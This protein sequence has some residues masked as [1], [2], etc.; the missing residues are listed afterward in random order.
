MVNILSKTG[1]LN[2][3]NIREL[4]VVELTHVEGGFLPLVCL[5]AFV[6]IEVGYH[7]GMVLQ[8]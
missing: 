1:E 5:A 7:A 8:E 6:A 3:M 4:D 2:M